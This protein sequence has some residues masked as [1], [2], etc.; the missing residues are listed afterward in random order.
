MLKLLSHFSRG[1]GYKSI[2]WDQGV[3]NIYK[4]IYHQEAG[5]PIGPRPMGGDKSPNFGAR[6]RKMVVLGPKNA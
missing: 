6:N 1:R 5:F 4:T 3:D 2:L